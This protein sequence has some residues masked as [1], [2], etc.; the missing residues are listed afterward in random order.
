MTITLITPVW[1]NADTIGHCLRSIKD[2]TTACQHILVDGGSTDGTLEIIE[3]HK[4]P[5][6]IL[7][8]EPDQG[9]YDAI[10][11]GLKHSTGDVIGILNADD[12]YA[13]NSVLSMV[14]EAFS[15]PTVDAC[16]G[17]LVYVDRLDTEK[18]VR[19]WQSG[20]F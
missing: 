20:S 6:T 4:A 17:D 16:Y 8:S 5:D 18:I 7:I 14:S 3:Q 10:N 19:N 12:Y 15:D 2:Q 13:S 9:M 11:K 1:N